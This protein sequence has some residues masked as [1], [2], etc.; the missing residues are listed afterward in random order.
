MAKLIIQEWQGSVSL[1]IS[2]DGIEYKLPLETLEDIIEY[3]FEINLVYGEKLGKDKLQT[4][5]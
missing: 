1:K 3:L 5:L 4:L 2:R